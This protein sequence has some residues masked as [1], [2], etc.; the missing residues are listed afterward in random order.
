MTQSALAHHLGKQLG[1]DASCG[2]QNESM[3]NALKVL[4]GLEFSASYLAGV[5]L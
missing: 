5:I 1:H 4:A 2:P 3:V